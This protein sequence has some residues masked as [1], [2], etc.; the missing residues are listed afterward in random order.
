[1]LIGCSCFVA[2]PS[3]PLYELFPQLSF[4]PSSSSVM[5]RLSET[6]RLGSGH[7][8]DEING[9]SAHLPLFVAPS[10]FVCCPSSVTLVLASLSSSSVSQTTC[11][12]RVIALFCVSLSSSSISQMTCTLRVIALFGVR[13]VA[14]IPINSKYLLTVIQQSLLLHFADD[15]HTESYIGL[16]GVRYVAPLPNNNKHL[17]TVIQQSL[18]LLHFADDMHTESYIGLL[19]LVSP[20]P[21][22]DDTHTERYIALFSVSLASSSISQT[23]H[24]LR[25]I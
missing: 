22:A 16:F 15:M 14:A 6:C 18:L 25:V 9:S 12:L 13:Y 5:L 3:A 17:L 11:T 23:T 19:V 7:P 20:P 1:M 2:K 21:F 10:P 4:P 8:L 24:T